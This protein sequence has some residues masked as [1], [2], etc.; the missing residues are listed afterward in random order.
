[1]LEMEVAY[2]ILVL[3]HS[4]TSLI[5]SNTSNVD[6]ELAE[7]GEV[8]EISQVTFQVGWEIELPRK[9]RSKCSSS[10]ER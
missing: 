6:I 5:R 1:M 8:D 10:T 7:S 9:K 2:Q 3:V 4:V